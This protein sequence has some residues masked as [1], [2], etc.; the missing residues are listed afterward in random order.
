M[1]SQCRA[2]NAAGSPCSATPV[3]ASG[4]CYWH[5]PSLEQERRQWRARGGANR[6]NTARA[7]RHLPDAMSLDELQAMLS[8]VLKSVVTKK[9]VPGV[10]NA[11]ANLARAMVAVDEAAKTSDFD[12]RLADL[13][14]VAGS[15]R[16]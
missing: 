4:W 1:V 5:D 7:R 8:V 9:T 3:R 13:E 16:R 14:R 11:V 2:L 12:A 10:G 6:S 15:G